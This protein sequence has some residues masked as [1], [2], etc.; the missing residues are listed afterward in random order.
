[1]NVVPL[2]RVRVNAEGRDQLIRLKRFTGIQS[3]NV[4]CRWALMR[5]LAEAHPPAVPLSGGP[6]NVE[7][8]WE[9]FA[10]PLGALPLL[11]VRA[12]N[13]RHGLPVDDETVAE[14]LHHHLHRGIATLAASGERILSIEDLIRPASP[15][16]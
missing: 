4:L 2:R 6:S 5:S 16:P 12:F 8:D 15:A 1:M 7:M 11:L 9:V 13:F 3:W 14:Q 10:G